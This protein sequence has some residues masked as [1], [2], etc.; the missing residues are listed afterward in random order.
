MTDMIRT[1]EMRGLSTTPEREGSF[2]LQLE[3]ERGFRQVVDFGL[4]G[5]APLVIDEPP[6]TGEGTGPNPARVLGAAV[7]SCLGA[8]LL[9]CLRKARIDVGA[10]HTTVE[11]ELA[12]N[13]RGR[14]RVTGLT[15]TLEPEI[16]A[17]QH[18][19][20]ARCLEIF[21]D[22]CVVTGSVRQAIDVQVEVRPRAA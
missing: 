21:E 12:R 4:E 5:V 6:P 19:R 17:E 2:R 18:G 14:L 13:E 1:A 11:G 16:P 20:I 3:G 8:S 15:V 10:L 22:F 7:G 9:F